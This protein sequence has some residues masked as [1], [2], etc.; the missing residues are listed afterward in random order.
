[1]EVLVARCAENLLR[2]ISDNSRGSR[3][4][5][6]GG[7]LLLSVASILASVTAVASKVEQDGA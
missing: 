5:T 3:E 4:K 1:M 2:Q 7:E 6:E